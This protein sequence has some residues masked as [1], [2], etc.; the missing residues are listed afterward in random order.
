MARP[1]DQDRQVQKELSGK[2]MDASVVDRIPLLKQYSALKKD[3]WS[4]VDKDAKELPD[5][6][7]DS[8]KAKEKKPMDVKLSDGS[9]SHIDFHENGNIKSAH[10]TRSNG[11][12]KDITFN[13]DGKPIKVKEGGKE[14][15]YA[16][17]DGKLSG[18]DVT[19]PDGTKEHVAY[20]DGKVLTASSKKGDGTEV[21]IDYRRKPGEVV[22]NEQTPSEITMTNSIANK[23]GVT[24]R[25]YRDHGSTRVETKLP[26]EPE[27]VRPAPPPKPPREK[28]NN[29]W[30]DKSKRFKGDLA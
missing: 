17:T 25:Y 29:D 16:Y 5:L 15:T 28:L 13:E 18:K 20:R 8:A 30:D 10:I 26:P 4:A 2:E 24:D 21:G 12:T 7:I 6:V 3:A 1:V 19:Y 23:P 11:D 9:T 22:A 27:G 14:T